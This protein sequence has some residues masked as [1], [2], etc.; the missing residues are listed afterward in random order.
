MLVP[1][2][3]YLKAVADHGSFTRA[4]AALHVSQPALSQQIRELKERMGVQP[5]RQIF[6]KPRLQDLKDERADHNASDAADPAEDDHHQHH[7]R[8]WKH[9]H[10]RGHGLQFGDIEGAGS[11]GKGGLDRKREELATDAVDA[12]RRGSDLVFADRHP[13]AADP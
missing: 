12:H 10:L 8:D 11:A 5:L 3:R 2:V 7:D 1:S 9:E 13:G 6:E 4:A